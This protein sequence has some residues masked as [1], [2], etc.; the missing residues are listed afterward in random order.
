MELYLTPCPFLT[1][2]GGS[3]YDIRPRECRTYPHTNKTEFTSRLIVMVHNC[4]ICPVVFE[5]FERLKD[6]YRDAF[7]EFKKEYA[8][9]FK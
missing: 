2:K 1:E 4:E 3:I 8:Y 9:L 5:I 6:I 7:E